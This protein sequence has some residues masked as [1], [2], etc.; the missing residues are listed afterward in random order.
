MTNTLSRRCLA[1]LVALAHVLLGCPPANP[2]LAPT[3]GWIERREVNLVAVPGGLV[4]VAGGKLLV[5]R[6]D[7]VLDTR[8]GRETL[9][10][11]YDSASGLWRWSFESQY[12][13]SIFVD[14]SGATFTVGSL[15]PGAALPGTHWV[16][17]DATRMATK[18]GLVHEY[19]ADHRLAAR[20]WRSDPY[21]RIVQRSALVAGAPRVREID[22][23]TSASACR[24]T[25]PPG[26]SRTPAG[27]C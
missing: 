22:Q 14:E 2:P 9:G 17:L 20:Y 3:P 21:P 4:D 10:A 25:G 13:G 19:G 1:L 11:V 15:A 16:K 12:D 7:L 27:R 18:G 5:H 8:L 26:R 23:C 6:V 24:S